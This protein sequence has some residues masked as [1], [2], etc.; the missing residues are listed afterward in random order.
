MEQQNKQS[1]NDSDEQ[2]E[3]SDEDYD[4]DEELFNFES[5]ID[6]EGLLQ[7]YFYDD[8]K[9]RNIVHVGIEIKR[10]IEKL[11][12]VLNKILENIKSK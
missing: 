2:Q 12:N 9:D 4:G 8:E 10:S 3:S 7:K 5:D 1:K 6:Y 11:T